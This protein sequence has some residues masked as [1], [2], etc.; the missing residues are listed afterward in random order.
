MDQTPAYKELEDRLSA[1]KNDYKQFVEKAYK[2]RELQKQYFST[3]SS[4]VLE[5]CKKIEKELD[6]MI[7][8]YGL[9]QVNQA[10]QRTIF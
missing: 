2:L 4:I 5:K 1:V 6:K 9:Q 10:K 3:R 8:D 7:I